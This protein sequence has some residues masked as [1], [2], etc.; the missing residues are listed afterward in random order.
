MFESKDELKALIRQEVKNAMREELPKELIRQ[1]TK[2]AAAAELD[3]IKSEVARLF[4]I[5]ERIV[6]I[7]NPAK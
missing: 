2:N 7:L 6:T 4:K 1:E 3:I 5:V